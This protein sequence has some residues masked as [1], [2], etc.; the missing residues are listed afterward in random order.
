MTTP[1]STVDLCEGR[2]LLKACW[3]L[4]GKKADGTC[5]CDYCKRAARWLV[6]SFDTRADGWEDMRCERGYHHGRADIAE[7]EADALSDAACALLDALPECECAD[8]RCPELDAGTHFTDCVTECA[9]DKI[10][11]LEALL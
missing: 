9:G 3:D 2:K 10:K 5:A 4:H 11:A 1:E 7:G 6:A 8:S